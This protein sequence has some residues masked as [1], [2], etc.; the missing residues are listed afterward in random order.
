MRRFFHLFSLTL[1]CMVSLLAR[2]HR[3]W[4]ILCLW[5]FVRRGR[6]GS[7]CSSCC[8]C[9]PPREDDDKGLMPASADGALRLAS[10]AAPAPA[11]PS[12]PAA[13]SRRPIATTSGPSL[14]S[15]ISK[16]RNGG[17]GERDRVSNQGT[18]K[19]KGKMTKGTPPLSGRLRSPRER[20]PSPPVSPP[21]LSLSLTARKPLL[22]SSSSSNSPCTNTRRSS[23]PVRLFLL[24]TVA[25]RQA[26]AL[27]PA[28]FAVS[29][30]SPGEK[31]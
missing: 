7:S 13:V 15:S 11:A 24:S 17:D 18:K 21:P 31:K 4:R 8:C 1:T 19:K 20:C 12:A 28:L 6:R 30:R 25:Q 27:S 23:C 26:T 5:F 16:R 2:R 14:S 3:F 10:V 29:A 9:S 22:Y